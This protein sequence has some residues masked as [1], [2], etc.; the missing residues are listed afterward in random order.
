MRS[1]LPALAAALIVLAG[2]ATQ[3]ASQEFTPDTVTTGTESDARMRARIHAELAAGYYEL[4]NMSVALEEISIAQRTDPAYSPA[5]NVAGLIYAAL[6]EDRLAEQNFQQALRI[7]P[8]DSDAHN[9]YGWYLCQRGRERES[10]KHFMEA[11]RN[12][13]YRNPDRSYLNAGLCAR[14]VGDLAGAE[15]HFQGALKSNPNH[16]QALYQLADLNFARGGDEMA[17]AHLNRLMQVSTPNAEAL[18]LGVRLARR[19]GDRHAQESYALQL[20]Q[21]FPDSKEARALLAGQ[22]E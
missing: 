11:L 3:P 6:K 14:R 13:L 5:Y 9:N 19:L 21:N 15:G 2:C 18:W 16:P 22:Y 4:G 7:N 20:R 8:L 10:I 1:L 12:P 17:K